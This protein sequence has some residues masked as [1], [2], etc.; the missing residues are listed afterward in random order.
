MIGIVLLVGMLAA[1]CSAEPS[2]GPM[3]ESRPDTETRQRGGDEAG[4]VLRFAVIGDS[5]W[6][7]REQRALARRMCRF[8]RRHPFDLVF[9]TG[10]NVYPDGA[11]RHFRRTFFRPYRCLLRR[12]VR[13]HASLGNHDYLARRGR[14]QLRTPAFG[15]RYRNYVVRT[16]GVRFVIADSMRLRVEWLRRSLTA[17]P[18]DNWTIA[19]FHHP[20]YSP[21]FHGSTPGFRA[22]LPRLLRR[23]GVDLVLN[24]HDH[25]YSYTRPLRR[26]RYVV[27]GGGGAPLY[28]CSPR[29]FARMCRE[30]HH[31][32]Y[33]A[34]HPRRIWVRAVPIHGAPVGLF[35]T[36]GR[37]PA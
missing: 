18:G 26:I 20:V 23:K 17:Q 10:D 22:L 16:M 29:W 32:L 34:A 25:I 5:G 2:I 33:V 19:I 28:P 24:G 37:P 7:G 6:G 12:D 11:R 15:M 9:T 21:G 1:A 14:P 13:F 27:T 36:P 30:I 8:R 3:G 35:S 4:R 31:F